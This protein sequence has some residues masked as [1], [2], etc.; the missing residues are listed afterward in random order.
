[1]GGAIRL[2][3]VEARLREG[4]CSSAIDAFRWCSIAETGTGTG[5][6]SEVVD[7]WY[8]D[9][10]FEERIPSSGMKAC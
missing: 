2:D 4:S 5:A 9:L 8:V 1:M 6:A 3:M 7:G 10:R